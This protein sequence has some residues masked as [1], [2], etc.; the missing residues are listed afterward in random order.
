MRN[1]SMESQFAYIVVDPCDL[2][3]STEHATESFDTQIVGSYRKKT[4]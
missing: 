1:M 2:M 3:E 4:Q